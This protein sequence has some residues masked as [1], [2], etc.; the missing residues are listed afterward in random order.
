MM[1]KIS[2]AADPCRAS[3]GLCS[4][5]WGWSIVVKYTCFHVQLF[6][7]LIPSH[8][9]SPNFW[10][11]ISQHRTTLYW[12]H[13][14]TDWQGSASRKIP[15]H[16]ICPRLN[17]RLGQFQA[18]VLLTWLIIFHEFKSIALET[19]WWFWQDFTS[20][21]MS[22]P[23]VDCR[24]IKKIV[25]YMRKNQKSA[26][27]SRKAHGRERPRFWTLEKWWLVVTILKNCIEI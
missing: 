23:C 7:D 8:R 9:E 13:I 25:I 12:N 4:F 27:K 3:Q 11:V 15:S 1:F 19:N 6:I 20:K 22:S 2:W 16:W 24:K 5:D 10:H 26:K 21:N 14:V 17:N 18:E